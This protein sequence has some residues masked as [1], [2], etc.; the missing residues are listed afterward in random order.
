MS[1]PDPTRRVQ[2]IYGFVLLV[3]VA[4]TTWWIVDQ[5]RFTSE[6]REQAEATLQADV[7]QAQRMLEA[8]VE[9]EE[10][11]AVFPRLE[12]VP[13]GPRIDAE[14]LA[15]AESLLRRRVVR[16]GWEGSFFLVVLAIGLVV[17]IRTLRQRARLL[18][19]QENFVAAVSHELKSPVASIR[20]TAE[21]LSLRDPPKE[22]RDRL[23]LRIQEETERLEATTTNLLETRRL[24][25]G[26]GKRERVPLD[27][28]EVVE[29]VVE[30][31]MPSFTACGVTIHNALPKGLVLLGDRTEVQIVVTNLLDNA[32]K[33]LAQAEDG[34]EVHL[35]GERTDDGYVRLTVSD[36][37]V[38]FPSSES[39][40]LFVKFYRLGDELRRTSRGVGLGLY[41]VRSLVEGSGGKVSATS[42]GVGKGATFQVL[43]PAAQEAA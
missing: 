38:G 28:A 33:A 14:A 5:A 17:L 21:T 24:E 42:E 11:E 43:W 12:F 4:Q 16:Y 36:N 20:L 35:E 2:L 26:G 39:N 18:R 10:V 3:C 6:V 40:R 22:R 34:P 13:S 9:L 8:G 32:G 15:A 25:E 19:W 31:V 1:S 7:V 30:S 27:L 23:L 29:K 41:L 37:G